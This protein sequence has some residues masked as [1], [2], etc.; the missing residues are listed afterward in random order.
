MSAPVSLECSD[1]I[2]VITV[3][4]PPVNA[5]SQAVRAG[6][7]DCF[8]QAGNDHG[9]HG[10]VLHC[11]GRTFIAGADI[12]EFGRAHAS[13]TLLEVLETIER[14]PKPVVAALHG[15]ALG[16]GL[17]TALCCSHRVASPSARIGLPEVKLGLLPGAG[18]T[19]R[20]PRVLGVPAALE[21]M[22]S[23]RMI[24]VDEVID[25]P[26]IDAIVEGELRE[27]AVAWLRQGLEQ[28][29]AP[30]R[31]RDLPVPDSQH[32]P[33]DFFTSAHERTARQMRGQLAPLQII[34]CVEAAATLPFDQGMKVERERFAECMASPQSAALRHMFFAERQTAKLPG[35]PAGTPQRPVRRVAVIGAGTMGGGIAMCFAN[36]GLPVTL[37][38]TSEAALRRGRNVILGNYQRSAAHGRLT[39]AQVE[40]RM[41]CI[42][43][44]TALSAAAGADLVIEAVFEDMTLK[45]RIFAELGAHCRPDAILAS[46]TS[47]LDIEEIARATPES[48][49]V[50]GLHFFS[51]ANVMRLL[52]IVRGAHT[53]D[54]VLATCL[55]LSRTIGKI[56]VVSGVC[57]GFIGNRMLE[58]YGREAGMLLLEGATPQDIDRVIVEFGLP[59]GPHA[60]GD[61]AG[62]DVG[63]L[64]RA[65]RRA[66]GA[67]PNDP[68]Y[69][70]VGDRLAALGRHG[71]K[72]G[73]GIY[74][75]GEDRR[76]PQPDPQVAALIAELADALGVR[77]RRIDDEEILE[78]CLYP[79]VNEGLRILEEGIALR[80]SDID[81]VWVYGY[82]FPAWRGGPMHWAEHVGLAHVLARL[83]HY[84]GLLGNEHGY[85]TPAPLLER[86][87]A[88]GGSLADYRPG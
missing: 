52:E 87:V 6:L 70:A 1:G 27:A 50:L 46:N 29:L 42:E 83:R 17:E 25:T 5:L 36:A 80:A 65:E 82:G 61:L 79:L 78:R 68:R 10:I 22:V 55:A 58:G 54:D 76:T 40:A 21:A 88:E 45:K 62:T 47:T 48:S 12:S 37:I 19:Q 15:T 64:V 53:A 73:K 49:R 60:M 14:M 51:P 69:G 81:V 39:D 33:A 9:V 66:A 20:L 71:Q 41:A 24:P 4:H 77:R 56:G 11:A 34:H 18:G 32:L 63:A 74:A 23:G 30:R 84:A 72:T 16:G 13:P 2:A 7:V 75:Y 59:M 44:A 26:A 8:R 67:L 85:W 28:G 86:L 38:D 43:G 31:V 35:I 3:N 57:Y